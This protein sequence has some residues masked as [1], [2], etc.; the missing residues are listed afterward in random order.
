MGIYI[1]LGKTI[2]MNKL[3]LA[4]VF[5]LFSAVFSASAQV[6][7]GFPGDSSII[8]F[9]SYSMPN[10]IPDTSSSPVWQIGYSRKTFFGIDSVGAKMI[11]TDTLN[12]Y[13]I[14]CNN[15]FVIKNLEF[16][17]I[18]DFW[19][20]YQTSGGHDGGIVEFSLDSGLT[21]QNLKGDCNVDSS[22]RFPGVLT[23]N[24]YT[25]TDTLNTGEPAFTGTQSST[26]FS[27]IQF[28]FG[29]V[30]GP[31][32]DSGCLVSVPPA[33]YLRFRFVSDSIADSL[34]G[35][36]IDSIKLENDI[37][38]GKVV[39]IKKKDLSIFPNP[40]YDGSFN[41][42]SLTNEQKYT[43]EV[44]NPI[45]TKLLKIPYV[46]SLELEQYPPGL[47]FYKVSDGTEYYS[48]RLLKE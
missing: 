25:K 10:F 35:W 34:A 13:R 20:K 5:L 8:N 6:H 7:D 41:F 4:I 28:Y 15:W 33:Y 36:I 42:P 46:H 32:G 17:M 47:Y 45:G 11:M 24:F 14:N 39:D 2:A 31:F 23:T 26:Q 18:V 27:R 1:P 21:W 38:W 22:S 9:S 12:P 3:I 19:H 44:F 29:P 48:G 30:V 40:S 16:E 43:I 37:Y